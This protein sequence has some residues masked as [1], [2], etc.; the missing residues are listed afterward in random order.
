MRDAHLQLLCLPLRQGHGGRR[1]KV[2]TAERL[3]PREARRR[4]PLR[5]HLGLRSHADGP[6]RDARG[7]PCDEGREERA[8]PV[9]VP[10]QLPALLADGLHVHRARGQPRQGGGQGGRTGS[11]GG[12]GAGC[13]RLRAAL[14]GLR[15]PWQK[16]PE[17]LLG[18]STGQGSAAGDCS[19]GRIQVHPQLRR[20]RL[21]PEDSAGQAC[22]GVHRHRLA[23]AA[24]G[25]PREG[26]GAVSTPLAL[27][28]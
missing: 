22:D 28:A 11:W 5:E 19:R 10:V 25:G 16:G 14:G 7:C 15:E 26:S 23:L 4:G 3:G 12:V 20:A 8:E 13:R 17:Y 27:Q 2:P 21:P 1:H 18:G 6:P 9:A 24:G